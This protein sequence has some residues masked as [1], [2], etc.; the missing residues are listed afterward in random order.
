M[1]AYMT[2]TSSG[3]SPSTGIPV[4]EDSF[5]TTRN[6]E[7]PPRQSIL[8]TFQTLQTIQTDFS[9]SC[10]SPLRYLSVISLAESHIKALSKSYLAQAF[11][12]MGYVRL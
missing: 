4:A 3:C 8:Q 2:S 5:P 7:H 11:N 6:A 1:N 9:Y 12:D 10:P